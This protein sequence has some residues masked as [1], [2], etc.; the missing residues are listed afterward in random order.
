MT[1]KHVPPSRLRYEKSHPTLSI[2]L[3]LKDKEIVLK[4]AQKSGKNISQILQEG[5][6]LVETKTDGAYRIGYK[7]GRK[8]GW[9]RFEA[10]CSNCGRPME[11]DIKSSEN[12]R[13]C[14]LAAFSN[15]YH[16][17]CEKG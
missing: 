3:S 11:F 16:T 5:L 17:D 9:G 2:R 4:I 10:P 14:L 12:V 13:D 1:R 6:R 8:A 15:W 7:E